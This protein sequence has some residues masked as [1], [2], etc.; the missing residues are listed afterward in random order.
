M[1]RGGSLLALALV[2]LTALVACGSGDK[3]NPAAAPPATAPPAVS[4]ADLGS[5]VIS[6]IKG[7]RASTAL[8]RRIRRGDVAGVIVMG[9]NVKSLGQVRSL[10]RSLRAAARAGGQLPPLVMVD[11]EGGIVKRFAT[12][13]PNR[14]ARSMSRLSLKNIERIGAATASDLLDR[15]VNVDLAPVADVV[16]KRRNF[17]GTRA[18][19]GSPAE[20][21]ERACAFSA[22]LTG[23]GVASS[24]KHFPGLGAA[25]D[26]NTDDG[27]VRIAASREQLT[28]GWGAYERCGDA[29]LTTIMVSSAVYPR[30]YGSRQALINPAVYRDLRAMTDAVVVTD[31]LNAVAVKRIRSLDMRAIAAGA[32]LLLHLDERSAARATTRLRAAL[33]AGRLKQ[34]DVADSVQRVRALRAELTN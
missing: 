18:F 9:V 27:G 10:T 29:P 25:A 6:G 34:S 32:D 22:G 7:T 4:S 33:R 11:Q 17:L 20:V 21:A 12:A 1:L 14:S 28:A 3:A 26:V 24:L 2:A 15:G 13:A 19:G 30:A 23:A 8:K 31:A 5:L 16:T